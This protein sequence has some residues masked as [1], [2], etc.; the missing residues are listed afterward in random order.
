MTGSQGKK[1]ETNL[2]EKDK[3]ILTGRI[4]PAISACVGNRG[5]IILSLFAFYSFILTDQGMRKLV[6]EHWWVKLGVSALF[7]IFIVHNGV[8]YFLNAKEQILR[9]E[10]RSDCKSALRASRM[11]IL[12]VLVSL[13]AVIVAHWLIPV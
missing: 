7:A 12:F 5:K 8:N 2:S 9:E 6:H 1:D 4:Y 3:T 10:G 13:V 11:E